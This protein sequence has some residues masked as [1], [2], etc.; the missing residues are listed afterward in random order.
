MGRDPSGT[1]RAVSIT[2]EPVSRLRQCESRHPP[3]TLQGSMSALHLPSTLL[4]QCDYNEGATMLC[5]S[6]CSI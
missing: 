2:T 5:S 1:Q 6:L 4:D 3:G